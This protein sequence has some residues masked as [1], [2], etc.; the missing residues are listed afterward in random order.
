MARKAFFA[1]PSVMASGRVLAALEGA[2]SEVAFELFGERL[3]SSA[4]FRSIVDNILDA[5]WQCSSSRRS[6][7]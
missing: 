7:S 5:L 4:A 6:I 3:K 2:N 1:Y